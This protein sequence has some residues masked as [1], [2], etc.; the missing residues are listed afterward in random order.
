M[1]AMIVVLGLTASLVCGAAAESSSSKVSAPGAKSKATLDRAGANTPQQVESKTRA[2]ALTRDADAT[3]DLETLKAVKPE[4]NAKF[5][6][7]SKLNAQTGPALAAAKAADGGE[8]PNLA[9]VSASKTFISVGPA[10]SRAEREPDAVN[11]VFKV[12]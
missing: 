7:A 10:V 1:R 6:A 3:V 8:S 12:R 4:G 11:T 5:A 2:P 9:P